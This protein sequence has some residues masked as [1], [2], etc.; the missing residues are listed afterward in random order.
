MARSWPSF[1]RPLLGTVGLARFMRTPLDDVG[2]IV[3]R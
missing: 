1:A 3:W 2:F